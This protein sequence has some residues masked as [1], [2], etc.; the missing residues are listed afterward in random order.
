MSV[1][2]PSSKYKGSKFNHVCRIKQPKWLP[3]AFVPNEPKHSLDNS[4]LHRFFCIYAKWA[5]NFGEIYSKGKVVHKEGSEF[6]A[7]VQTKVAIN[8]VVPY[9]R[10]HREL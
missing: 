10:L 4:R 5:E 9:F 2:N 7:D 1:G 6:D 8:N 3:F